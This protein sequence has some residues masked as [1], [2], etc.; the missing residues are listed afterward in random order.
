[1]AILYGVDVKKLS[2]DTWCPTAFVVADD[3][4]EAK[5]IADKRYP[6]D[7]YSKTIFDVEESV[8]TEIQRPCKI[9]IEVY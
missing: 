7:Q 3:Y 9:T 8:A 5:E 1:M 6:P 4:T 2:T